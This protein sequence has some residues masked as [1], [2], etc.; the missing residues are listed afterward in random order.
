VSH[1]YRSQITFGNV[2]VSPTP[3]PTIVT[4]VPIGR[5]CN[6]FQAFMVLMVTDGRGNQWAATGGVTADTVAGIT[7]FHAR[8]E[9]FY[10][11]RLSPFDPGADPFT[12]AE[13][14]T[15]AVVDETPGGGGAGYTSGGTLAIE[16]DFGSNQITLITPVGSVT[17]LLNEND[18][19]LNNSALNDTYIYPFG[20]GATFILPADGIHSPE[21]VDHQVQFHDMQAR[22]D[23][24]VF[25]SIPMTAADPGTWFGFTNDGFDVDGSGKTLPPAYHAET[26]LTSRFLMEQMVAIANYPAPGPPGPLAPFQKG[27][28]WR[29]YA[30]APPISNDTDM[31]IARSHG[32]VWRGGPDVRDGSVMLVQ[33]TFDNA[34]SWETWTAFSDP[35]T[36]NNSPTVTWYNERV[37]L[38]WFDGTDIRECHSVDGGINWSVPTTIPFVGTNPRR[39]VDRTGGGAFYFYFD[40]NDLKVVISYDSGT[41]FDGPYLVAS[42]VG[43]QQIDAEFVPDGSL[44]ASLFVAGVWSQYRSRDLGHSWS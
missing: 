24:T 38:T 12:W 9:L 22:R 18:S 20:H 7:E 37:N 32:V 34:G 16:K 26:Q 44:V 2:L 21:D 6:V 8:Y 11:P 28:I 17:R 27:N 33:R 42:A 39:V 3:D 43:V 4:V 13:Y 40:G 36:S 19:I 35:L 15:P 31:D 25:F 41:S 23:T 14:G 1:I 5:N 29:T 30:T 10:R